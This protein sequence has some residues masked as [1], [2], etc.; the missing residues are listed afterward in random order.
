MIAAD[1]IL[2]VCICHGMLL[3]REM[4]VGTEI[5]DPD[6]MGLHL[7]AGWSLVK[8]EY[9]RFYAWLVENARR[10]A[11]DR[12]QLGGLQELLANDF[13]GTGFEQH[14]VRQNHRRPAGCLQDGIDV[15]NEIELLVGGGY[16]EILAAVHEI[17]LFLLAFLVGHGDG[18]LFAERRIGQHIIHAIARICQQRI[19]Q[20]DRDGRAVD[21]ADIVQIQVHQA[22]LECAGHQLVSIEG[23]VLEECLLLTIHV[24]ASRRGQVF[25]CGEEEAAAAAAWVYQDTIFDTKKKAFPG[26]DVPKKAKIKGFPQIFGLLEALFLYL[27]VWQAVSSVSGISCP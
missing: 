21:I 8:E 23:T 19:A 7:W 13:T 20:R 27:V 18:G 16:P 12:V 22:Q 3:E 10:Q 2:Q 4:H 6:I 17:L 15:L 25:L 24:I 1:E 26:A 14:I 5:V 11:Q 9:V